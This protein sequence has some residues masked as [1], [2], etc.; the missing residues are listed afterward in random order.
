ML[1]NSLMRAI[2]IMGGGGCP[3]NEDKQDTIFSNEVINF[4]KPK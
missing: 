3:R 2:K 1:I 4:G